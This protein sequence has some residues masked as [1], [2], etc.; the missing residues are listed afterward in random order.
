MIL[1]TKLHLY[2]K[3]SI[4]YPLVSF[5]EKKR[6]IFIKKTDYSDVVT[7]VNYHGMSVWV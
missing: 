3:E 6:N 1:A 2:N 4:I 7:F 5:R